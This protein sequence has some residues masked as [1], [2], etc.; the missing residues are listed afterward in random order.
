MPI[1][2]KPK[3]FLGRFKNFFQKPVKNTPI[4]FDA[5]TLPSSTHHEESVQTSSLQSPESEPLA[6]SDTKDFNQKAFDAALKASQTFSVGCDIDDILDRYNKILKNS[7]ASSSR[8][9]SIYGENIS[10][11]SVPSQ[12]SV[13]LSDSSQSSIPASVVPLKPDWKHVLQIAVKNGTYLSET[14]MELALRLPELASSSDGSV[15]SLGSDEKS[16]FANIVD[17]DYPIASSSSLDSDDEYS[18]ADTEDASV[19]DS[20]EETGAK[21]DTRSRDTRGFPIS[22]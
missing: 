11:H 9:S 19:A 16:F 4:A 14:S 3:A 17:R 5:T 10:Y 1:I 18:F 7:S 15:S 12:D 6:F 8:D 2:I 21:S 13:R 20:I 22:I